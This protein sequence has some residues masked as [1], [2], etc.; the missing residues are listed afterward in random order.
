MKF[1]FDRTSLESTIR[2]L[3]RG[4][5]NKLTFSDNFPINEPGFQKWKSVFR[6]NGVTIQV[7][8]TFFSKFQEYG[9]KIFISGH[10][11][12]TFSGTPS[13][14]IYISL[15]YLAS[16]DDELFTVYLNDGGVR[17]FGFGLVKN[18]REI[19]I[20]RFDYANFTNGPVYIE[21][22]GSYERMADKKEVS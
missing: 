6:S 16:A 21:L 22:N 10:W 4:L 14:E 9:P 1:R 13:N 20:R 3:I 5:S 12:T 18:R 17:Q 2:E 7:D 11:N 19:L 15:P 8:S